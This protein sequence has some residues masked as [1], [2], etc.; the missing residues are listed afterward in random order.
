LQK[1]TIMDLNSVVQWPHT[2]M[3]YTDP[4][5][6]GLFNGLCLARANHDPSVFKRV[7]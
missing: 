7:M 1:K 5:T 4:N 3:F 2:T 6:A